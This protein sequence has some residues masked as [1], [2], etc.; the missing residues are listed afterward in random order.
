M[1]SLYQRMMNKHNYVKL[2]LI[3]AMSDSESFFSLVPLEVV[4]LVFR[5]LYHPWP[6]FFKTSK[7]EDNLSVS[8]NN[9]T[10][11]KPTR[12]DRIWDNICTSHP[13]DTEN[14]NIVQF[15]IELI[16]GSIRGS[17]HLGIAPDLFYRSERCI[18]PTGYLPPLMPNPWCWSLHCT[19]RFLF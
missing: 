6:W 8:R 7:I 10:V 11:S 12:L 9:L 13:L 5:Y 16:E 3:F 15:N 14:I 18:A 19:G 17:Y 2:L 1:G 4:S